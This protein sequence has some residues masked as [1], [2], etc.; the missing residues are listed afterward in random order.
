MWKF[1]NQ[2]ELFGWFKFEK[3]R[4]KLD[5]DLSKNGKKIRENTVHRIKHI[6]HCRYKK[7]NN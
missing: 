2:N 1:D 4:L 5:K 3:V 7:L 6:V